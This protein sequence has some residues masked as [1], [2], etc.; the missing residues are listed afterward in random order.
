VLGSSLSAAEI[1]IETSR[2]NA[3]RT[4]T[5][6]FATLS[7]AALVA[8]IEVRDA[9]EDVQ[10]VATPAPVIDGDEITDSMCGRCGDGSCVASCGENAQTCPKDCGGVES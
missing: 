3:M 5:T 10:T 4:L 7:L 1:Q 2:G 9:R 8:G 6:V